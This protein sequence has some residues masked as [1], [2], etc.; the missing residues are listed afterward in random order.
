MLD[1]LLPE[2][3]LSRKEDACCVGLETSFLHL[4]LLHFI[5][6]S[7]FHKKASMEKEKG[8][9]FSYCED[10]DDCDNNIYEIIY[11]T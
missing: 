5:L 2:I 10:D 9:D 3:C 11:G 7:L 4:F 8:I 6:F 1:Q